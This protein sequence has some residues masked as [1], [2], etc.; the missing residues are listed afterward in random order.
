MSPKSLLPSLYQTFISN[1]M[2]LSLLT[3][4]LSISISSTRGQT[5][6][7]NSL[8]ACGQQCPTLLT[9]QAGCVPP[10]APVTS[11]NIYQSCFCLSDFLKPLHTGGSTTVCPAC[12]PQ[13]MGTIENWYQTLCASPNQG[14]PNQ[15][16]PDETPPDQTPPDQTPPDQAPPDTQTAAANDAADDST[17]APISSKPPPDN[18]GWSVSPRFM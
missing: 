3:L 11:P 5:L 8:P 18:K 17:G 13:D 16:P 4:V 14:S 9:A 15:A 1:K 6:I 10:A 12:S 2:S 7:A